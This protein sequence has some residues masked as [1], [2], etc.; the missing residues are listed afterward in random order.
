MQNNFVKQIE[1]LINP[2][3]IRHLK[4]NPDEYQIFWLG[5][6]EA[7]GRAKDNDKMMFFLFVYY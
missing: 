7:K 3:I 6:I 1:S 4:N 5:I 2:S